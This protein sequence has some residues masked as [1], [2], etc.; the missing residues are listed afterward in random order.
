MDL[1]ILLEKINNPEFQ[2]KLVAAAFSVMSEQATK[3]VKREV[4]IELPEEFLEL[5]ELIGQSTGTPVEAVLSQ[6]AHQGILQ[7]FKESFG[8]GML[9][10]KTQTD[11]VMNLLQEGGV[12]IAGL[13]AKLKKMEELAQ[14]LGHVQKAVENVAAG[15][16]TRNS[17]ESQKDTEE[18]DVPPRKDSGR[19]TR[20]RPSKGN[21]K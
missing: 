8:Q 13:G 9:K 21:A 18:S 12:D 6:M 1:K 15:I 20:K 5:I 19:K 16:T 3:T 7:Q 11:D 10:Q 14:Q 4:T 2:K 17:S